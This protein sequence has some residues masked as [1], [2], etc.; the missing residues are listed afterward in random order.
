MEY[1]LAFRIMVNAEFDL[2][3]LILKND[4]KVVSDDIKK[5]FLMEQNRA[6]II[7]N[8]DHDDNL[9]NDP[10]VGFLYYKYMIAV[11]PISE[12]V[13]LDLQVSLA[14]KMYQS[15]KTNGI[16]VEIVADFE[17]RL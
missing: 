2:I 13:S 3:H 11:F 7:L 14:K 1:E 5:T 17:E 9:V 4:F 10:E 16:L 15:F 6:E 12:E 8:E